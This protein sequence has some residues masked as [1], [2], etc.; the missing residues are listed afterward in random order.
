MRPKQMINSY[1]VSQMIS[2]YGRMHSN[3][4]LETTSDKG[5]SHSVMFPVTVLKTVE[6]MNGSGQGKEADTS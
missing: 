2:L 3:H 6:Q 4:M 1:L 5:A